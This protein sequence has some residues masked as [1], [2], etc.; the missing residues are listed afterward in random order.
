VYAKYRQ[1]QGLKEE[2][3]IPLH[4]DD[5]GPFNEKNH[6]KAFINEVGAFKIN[7][8]IFQS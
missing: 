1:R 8:T 5:L 3:L 2:L 4:P 6:T 7:Y